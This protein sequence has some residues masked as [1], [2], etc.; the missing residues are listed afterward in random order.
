[1]SVDEQR[2]LMVS[3][4]L[5]D[6]PFADRLYSRALEVIKHLGRVGQTV[7]LTNGDVVLQPRKLQRSG[8]WQAVEGR[9]LVCVHKEQMLHAIKRD[10]PA[11]HYVIVDDK[12]CILTAMKVIWQE[13]LITIF[14]RQDH[15][16]LD[17]AVVTG[18]PAADVTIESISE[19]ADLD[20]LPLIKQAANEACTTPEMP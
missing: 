7:L 4:F 10:Y 17:P 6:Y 20:L 1:M 18:Q 12:L 3:S 5:I 16:A 19:L 2:L 14:V 11:R 15:Y 13:Q 8:L 9:A